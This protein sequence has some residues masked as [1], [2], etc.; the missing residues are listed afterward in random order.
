MYMSSS[1]EGLLTLSFV[2]CSPPDVDEC[3][4]NLHACSDNCTNI[5]GSYMCG[6]PEGFGLESDQRTCMG[7]YIKGVYIYIYI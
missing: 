3:L 6:C 7:M 2:L 1:L 4:E 5:L